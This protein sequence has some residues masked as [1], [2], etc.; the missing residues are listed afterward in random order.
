M[1][2]HDQ[3]TGYYLPEKTICLTFDDGPGETIGD[4]PGPKTLMLARYLHEQ[5]IRATFFVVGKF[6]IKH[7]RIIKE[8]ARLGHIIG[9]HTFCHSDRLPH[10]LETGWDIVSEIAMTD[11]LIRDV[12]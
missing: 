9:N 7:P 10:L 5:Q 6:V 4:G 8:V 2:F 11:E 12:V 3:I 1:F